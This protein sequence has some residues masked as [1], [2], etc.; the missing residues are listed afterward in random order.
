MTLGVA[1]HIL[2]NIDQL[3]GLKNDAALK[4]FRITTAI[5]DSIKAERKAVQKAREDND[6][7][8]LDR[9]SNIEVDVE[10]EPLTQ[11]DL[12]THNLLTAKILRQFSPIIDL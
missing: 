3:D 12:K 1:F 6:T 4:L 2:Q 9:L 8:E 7:E 11:D 10:F 5:E